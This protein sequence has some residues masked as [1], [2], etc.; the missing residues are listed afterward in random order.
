MMLVVAILVLGS[1]WIMNHLNYHM[2][3]A[4][5]NSAIMKDEGIHK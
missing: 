4:G 5:T 3:P 1:L 2:S